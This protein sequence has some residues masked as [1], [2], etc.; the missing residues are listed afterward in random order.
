M[1][2]L[3]NAPENDLGASSAENAEQPSAPV[4]QSSTEQ[5]A[6]EQPLAEQP[7]PEQPVAEQP[8]PEQP[9]A[10]QPAPEQPA[11]EQ[12]APEQ[13]AAEQPA[14]EQTIATG[15]VVHTV[16]SDG[17]VVILTPEQVAAAHAE[18]E[19]ARQKRAEDKA[20]REA[21]AAARDAAFE[22]LT[23]IKEADGTVTI[24]ISER[25][26]GGLRADYNHLRLFLPASQL[27]L[28]RNPPE[29]ELNAAVGQQMEVHITDLTVDELGM[30]SAVVSRK[31]LAEAEAWKSIKVGDVLE[32][33]VRQVH[34]FGCFVSLGELEGLVHISRL[35]KSR[36]E[37]A[38]EVVKKGQRITVTVVSVDPATKKIGLSHKEHAPDLWDGVA[39][40]F[41]IGV[42]VPGTITRIAEYGAHVQVAPGVQ[43]MLRNAD[44]SWTQRSAVAAQMFTVGQQINVAVIEVDPKGRRMTVSYRLTQPNPWHGLVEELP[45]GTEVEGVVQQLTAQGA[46]VRIK[47]TI[48]AFMP[49]SRFLPG[50]RTGKISVKQGDTVLA[51]IVAV[52]PDR[53]SIIL[54]HRAEDGTLGGSDDA[55]GR[56]ERGFRDGRGR[57]GDR[58]DHSVDVPREHAAQSGGVALGDLLSDALRSNL[59]KG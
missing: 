27:G 12:P 57:G 30:K 8:A 50:V 42:I 7:A 37:S 38:E 23:K 46:V 2:D 14:A 53:Q 56:G 39:E 35:S 5:P 24:T 26:K 3:T 13:P 40:K 19:A 36:V 34:T 16:A 20:R 59:N 15:T 6:P 58:R 45:A 22:E 29:A 9:V 28:K 25:V 32:G 51:S 18:A 1:S 4:Q 11:A 47:E 52:E 10:E 41:T 44:L 17:P 33:I 55:G 49:R 54:A 48:D 31:R 21:E 43:A